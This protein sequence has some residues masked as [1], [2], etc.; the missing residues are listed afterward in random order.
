MACLRY[1]GHILAK[2][3]GAVNLIMTLIINIIAIWQKGPVS[4]CYALPRSTDMSNMLAYLFNDSPL[5]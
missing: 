3:L 2:S 5:L 4:P 1:V